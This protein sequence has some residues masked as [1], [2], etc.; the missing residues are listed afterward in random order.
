MINSLHPCSIDQKLKVCA[1][2]RISSDKDEQETSLVEQ[3]TYYSDINIY[4]ENRE[5]YGR[6]AD[7]GSYNG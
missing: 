5:F 3:I 1:Y 4:N 7:D 6:F 2:C